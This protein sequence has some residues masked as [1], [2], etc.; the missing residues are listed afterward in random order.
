MQHICYHIIS[1]HNNQFLNSLSEVK[2]T[3]NAWKAEGESRIKIFKIVTE[4][5]GSDAINLEE[6]QLA[7]DDERFK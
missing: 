6:E 3:V 2:S 5:L 1:D 4:E 7:I